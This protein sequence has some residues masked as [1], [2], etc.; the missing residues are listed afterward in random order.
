ML[1]Q[2]KHL[3][4]L[5]SKVGGI[6][7]FGGWGKTW[8]R[9]SPWFFSRTLNQ[10]EQGTYYHKKSTRSVLPFPYDFLN[11]VHLKCQSVIR[12]IRSLFSGLQSKEQLYQILS[13]MWCHLPAIYH[14]GSKAGGLLQTGSQPVLKSKTLSHLPIKKKKI[15]CIVYCNC[16]MCHQ[17]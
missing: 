9:Q 7:C 3:E 2:L 13:Q 15:T 11:L 16:D 6:R 8:I 4:G 17:E 10:Y 1:S 12:Q 14:S 5:P